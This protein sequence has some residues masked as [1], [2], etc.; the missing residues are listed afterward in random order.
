MKPIELDAD[1]ES[2]DWTKT[3]WDLPAY[4][5]PDFFAV[6][7]PGYDAEVFK[8]SETY[9]NAVANGLILDDEWVADFV[10]PV[11][12]KTRDVII[13]HHKD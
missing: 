4:N 8:Q 7:G 12:V 6:M 5:S 1:I 11:R 13:H 3:A 9:K 10:E 2:A